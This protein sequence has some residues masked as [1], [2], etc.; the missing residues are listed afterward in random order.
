MIVIFAVPAISPK[1]VHALKPL[2]Q[3]EIV[4]FKHMAENSR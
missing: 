2:F 3:P 1:F 4:A